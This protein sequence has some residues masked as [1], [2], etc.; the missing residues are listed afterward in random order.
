MSAALLLVPD[1]LL[2]AF[3]A[4]LRHRPAYPA[5]FWVGLERLVY[6]VLFPALLFLSLASAQQPLASAALPIA[7]IV[8]ATAAAVLLAA[9]AGPVLRLPKPMFGA[10]F[11]CA[12]RFNT[13]LILAVASR[14]GGNDAVA[15][16][17]VLVG[18]LVP[19]VNVA[20]VVAL[21]ERRV[22]T[23]LRELA[24]NP[25][26]IATVAGLA[27]HAAGLALP[28]LTAH[29]LKLL[30]TT[31]LPLGLLAVGAALRLERDAMPL[32]ALAWFHTIKLVVL[33]AIAWALARYAGLA[34]LQVQIVVLVACVPTAT[35]AY[36]LAVQMGGDGRAAAWL[37]TSG[38]LLAM[39]TMPVW[40]GMLGVAP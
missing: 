1:F 25:L 27:W 22:G 28:D 4:W 5:A 23:L 19:L 33:P 20:A 18:V 26:I 24:R 9:L 36:I 29:V 31:A 40:L 34:P 10:A 6:F 7:V 8:A 38:T 14:L 11:Q 17:S 12:F 2:I 32:A 13:Y 3:G 37:I 30:A 21:A 15:L 35:S 16:A 39:V